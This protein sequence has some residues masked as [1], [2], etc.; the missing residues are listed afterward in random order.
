M[1]LERVIKALVS[2]GLSRV[3]AEVYVYTAKKGPQ[4][5][6]DLDNALNYSKNQIYASLRT[7]IE[8]GLINKEGSTYS[9]IPFEEA[10]ESL[11]KNQR[12]E[13]RL[14]KETKKKLVKTWNDNS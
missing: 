8:L 11:I 2:L 10:L 5:V 6:M 7:L 13:E 14:L 4:S 12:E 3:D 1:S 9:A